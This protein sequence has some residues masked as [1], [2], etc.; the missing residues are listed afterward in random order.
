MGEIE[1]HSHLVEEKRIESAH[2]SN[3]HDKSPEVHPIDH[4]EESRDSLRINH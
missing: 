2:K 3:K 4:I 1:P